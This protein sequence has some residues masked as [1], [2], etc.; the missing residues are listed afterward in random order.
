MRNATEGIERGV[1]GKGVDR[2]GDVPPGSQRWTPL[3]ERWFLSLNPWNPRRVFRLRRRNRCVLG[4]EKRQRGATGKV[5][6]G[7]GD[8]DIY[9]FRP[10]AEWNSTRRLFGRQRSIWT[11]VI[12][13][14]INFGATGKLLRNWGACVDTIF[15]HVSRKVILM[16][17]RWPIWK[18]PKGEQR[19]E[20]AD[21]A[22][23]MGQRNILWKC[24]FARSGARPMENFR[25]SQGRRRGPRLYE[26]LDES[27]VIF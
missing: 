11:L 21:G 3:P 5:P 15:W 14:N 4:Q 19:L 6:T 22:C 2:E 26:N 16:K 7:E 23:L 8:R 1:E 24:W 12:M 9:N 20:L 13:I 27:V 17:G 10:R 18:K 25:W